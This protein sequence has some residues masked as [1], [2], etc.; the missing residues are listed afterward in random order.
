M[1]PRENMP[2]SWPQLVWTVLV[3]DFV[4][5]LLTILLKAFVLALPARAIP[6]TKRVRRRSGT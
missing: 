6:F 1:L 3:T 2:A 4:A 5:R